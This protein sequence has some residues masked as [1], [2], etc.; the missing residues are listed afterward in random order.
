MGIDHD[1]LALRIPVAL[2][3]AWD[4]LVGDR[5]PELGGEGLEG[6]EQVGVR[7]TL[8][9]CRRRLERCRLGA[10]DR[11]GLGGCGSAQPKKS[12]API[13]RR[14]LTSHQVALDRARGGE[15]AGQLAARELEVQRISGALRRADALDD[16]VA[17]AIEGRLTTGLAATPQPPAR[18]RARRSGHP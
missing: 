8:D 3:A 7:V 17:A 13:F 1:P 14:M 15:P 16:D 9:R 10:R 11:V 12:A 5:G 2:R 4:L 18:L 6:S